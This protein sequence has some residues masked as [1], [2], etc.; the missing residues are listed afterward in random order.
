MIDLMLLA[1]GGLIGFLLA[2][3]GAGGSI[4]LLPILVIGAGLPTRDAVPLSLLVVMVLAMANV[5]P[6]LRRSQLAIRPAV[7]LGIPALGGAWMGGSLVKAGLVAE[8]MQLLV[9]V[10][11]AVTA[12]VL[13]LRSSAPTSALGSG[14][15]GAR[16]SELGDDQLGSLQPRLRRGEGALALQGVVVGGLTGLAG[17]GGGFAIVPALV[18]LAGVPMPVATGTSLVLIALN[19]FVALM[20]LGHWPDSAQHLLVPLLM[21]GGGG[22]LLGQ[23]VAPQLNDRQLRRAFALLLIGSALLTGWEA[24]RRH[25][26]HTKHGWRQLPGLVVFRR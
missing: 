25:P 21:G 6:V 26:D 11:A 4:L 2:V 19:S 14:R 15:R 18:L 12:A 1:G 7:I 20:A 24:N 16:S 13:M 22:L 3:L 10:V 17:V 8:V 5:A 23:V 9:F